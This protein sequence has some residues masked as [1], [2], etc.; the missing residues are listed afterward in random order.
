MTEEFYTLGKLVQLGFRSRNFDGNTTLCMASAVSGYKLSFGSDGP[1]GI[2]RGHGDCRSHTADRRQHCG[3]PSHSVP[4]AGA[5]SYARQLD[6]ACHDCDCGR[7]ASNQDRDDGRYSSALK[8]RSD[9]AL[10]NGIAHVLIRE[11]LI[12]RAY[13]DAH[14]T[15]FEEFSAFVADFTPERVAEMTGFHKTTSCT[16]LASTAMLRPPLSVGP[17]V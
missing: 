8:P 14:T 5:Q 11:G 1:P 7:S 2:V 13:I 6:P 17:W 15:G 4:A 12:D 10:L 3:Q 16:P 9:I